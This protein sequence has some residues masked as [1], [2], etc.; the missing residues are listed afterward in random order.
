MT[1]PPAPLYL[2]DASGF[3]FRAFH[4]IPPMHRQDGTPVN[5][6]YGFCSITLKILQEMHASHVL[7]VFDAGRKTFRNDIYPAYK[8]NRPPT[9]EEL[10]PQFE[11]VRQAVD[12]FGLQR[13]ELDGVEA[14]DLIASYA[15]KALETGQPV[16]IVSSDKDLLQLLRPNLQIYDPVKQ[17]FL[18]EEASIAK[19]GVLPDKVVDVQALVGDTSDHVPGVPSIGVKTAAE[20]ITTFGSLEGVLDNI[21]HIKQPK[22]REALEHHQDNARLSKILC[23]LKR[24]VPLPINID[25]IDIHHG[26]LDTL[27]T[28]LARQSFTSLVHRVHASPATTTNA[29]LTPNKPVHHTITTLKEWQALGDTIMTEG[30]VAMLATPQEG[31]V[32]LD[33]AVNNDTYRVVLEKAVDLF[34]TAALD[35][36]TALHHAPWLTHPSVL[37]IGHQI[38]HTGHLLGLLPMPFH[39]VGLMSYVCNNSIDANDVTAIITAYTAPTLDI[40][41]VFDVLRLY[42]LLL[43]K[44]Y[45][46]GLLT[47]YETLERPLLPVLFEM[48]TC[49]ITLSIP[50]LH[51]LSQQFGNSIVLLEKDIMDLC[52]GVPFNIGSPKQLGEVLFDRLGLPNGKKSKTGH[53]TTSIDVLEPLAEAY[54]V[55]A[56]ILEWRQLSKLKSTYTDALPKVVRPTTNRVHTTF[57]QMLAST[58]R[59]SSLDPN[60]QNIPIRRIEGAKIRQAFVAEKNKVLLSADYS[61]IELRLLAECANIPSLKQ[62]FLNGEDIHQRTASEVFD[63]PLEHVT[64]DQRRSAKAINFG[65]IYGISAFGLAKQLGCPQKE[66]GA[67]ITRYFMRYPEIKA[68]MDTTIAFAHHHGYVTT[69]FGRRC[70]VPSIRDTNPMRRQLAE[71]A[72]INAPLQGTAADIIRR[73]MIHLQHPLKN[74]VPS[75]RLLL[76]VHDE[77]L[78]EVAPDAVEQTACLVKKTMEKA[79]E[80]AITLS[81]S[82]DVEIKIG[83]N[84]GDMVHI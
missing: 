32:I 33:I 51:T 71:R 52:G 6:V 46:E 59:L 66:A 3:I 56:K 54:P 53:Y 27:K 16:I 21:S 1:T 12:A 8:A 4:A 5:A 70:Y 17:V 76:Q 60:V 78:L 65:I 69:L 40:P 35:I 20:L 84:W 73:A 11:I 67:Y 15:T 57:N 18:N 25:K 44:L 37:K 23:T 82:L 9:P 29:P 75:A 72:A 49:G 13:V 45:Q 2:I 83:K 30:L 50:V 28:F 74:T 62:A 39:D 36:S 79:M 64:K 43:E 41:I 81:V 38:K 24:D 63:I 80:P 7:V 48:E 77:L 19:F 34:T 22:R 10:I 14:D 47:V 31:T 55:V 61:Q 58:G 42:P 68:Y 26:H